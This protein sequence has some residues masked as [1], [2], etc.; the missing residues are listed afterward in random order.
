MLIKAI[1]LQH[2][3]PRGRPENMKFVYEHPLR[4]PEQAV[5]ITRSDMNGIAGYV[6]S[7]DG[8]RIPVSRLLQRGY[9]RRWVSCID[10]SSGRRWA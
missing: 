4:V 9:D 7:A 2:F 10:D 5:E 3:E 6:T 1:I 8:E